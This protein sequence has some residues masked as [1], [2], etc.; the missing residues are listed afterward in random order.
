MALDL[1]TFRDN[2]NVKVA[3]FELYPSQEP[4]SYCVGFIVKHNTKSDS[5]YLDTCVP[6]ADADGLTNGEIT[7]LGWNTLETN[8]LTWANT[9]QNKND[10]VGSTFSV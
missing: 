10:I 6:L 4:T 3:R 1:T 5:R 8:Y 9:V 2:F 7:Q